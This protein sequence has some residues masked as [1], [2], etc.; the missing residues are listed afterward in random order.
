MH[1][2]TEVELVAVDDCLHQVLWTRLF[3]MSQGYSTGDTIIWQDNK[4]AMLLAENGNRS[5]SQ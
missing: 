2:S 1:S 3:L 5:S 4:S